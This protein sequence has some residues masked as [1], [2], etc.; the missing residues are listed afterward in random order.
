M[1]KIAYKEMFE[2]EL[3]H[4]W[5]L[6]TRKLMISF[7]QKYLK[8]NA[9]ILDAGCGTGGTIIYLKKKNPKWQLCGIDV[10]Q[11]ALN[12]CKKRNIK[13]LKLGSINKLP[14]KDD[15]FDAVVCLDVLYHK[16]INL[17]KAISEFDRILKPQGIIYVQEP[18][19]NW[20]K[21]KHD[22]AIETERRFTKDDL[23]ILAKKASFKIV[24]CSYFNSLLFIPIAVKRIGNKIFFS[25]TAESDVFQLPGFINRTMLE[26][27]NFEAKLFQKFDFPF[28]LSIICLAKK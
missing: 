1:K 15:Y 12:Y 10:S 11:I 16:G 27:L 21:S 6:A 28:G 2:N 19:F 8:K 7:L 23:E 9:K 20:L 3:T 14:Y 18:A 24:K 13:N 26:L 4:A 25:K 17:Q 5:Y 22:N